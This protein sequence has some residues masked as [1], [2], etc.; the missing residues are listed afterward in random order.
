M[1]WVNNLVRRLLKD[2]AFWDI[3]LVV[4]LSG[5]LL[6]VSLA[7]STSNILA[8]TVLALRLLELK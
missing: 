1:G 5:F 4:S 2:C 3:L 8:A 6:L 7:G